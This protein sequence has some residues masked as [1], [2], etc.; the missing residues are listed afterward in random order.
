VGAQRGTGGRSQ[1][2]K[3]GGHAIDANVNVIVNVNGVRGDEQRT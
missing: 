2:R 1:G 3:E